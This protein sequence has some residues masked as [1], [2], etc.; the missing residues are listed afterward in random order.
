MV[1]CC[2]PAQFFYTTEKLQQ[3]HP[4]WEFQALVTDHPHVRRYFDVFPYFQKIFILGRDDYSDVDRII[5]PL[6]NRGY[7]NIKRAAVGG[8]A[9]SWEVDYEGHLQSLSAWRLYLS[10][11]Y[12]PPAPSDF[13]RY[14]LKF[15]H[16]PLGEKI[17][18]LESCHPSLVSKTRKQWKGVLL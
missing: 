1:Q 3:R 10:V 12:V 2:H 18:F 8:S 17:L 5:F 13:G 4:H 15:P 11:F 9:N 16:P 14:L 7:W 6:L